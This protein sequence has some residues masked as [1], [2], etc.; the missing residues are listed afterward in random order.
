MTILNLIFLLLRN[1]KYI[2]TFELL[3]SK[4]YL[5]VAI[6]YIH[7]AHDSASPPTHPLYDPSIKLFLRELRINNKIATPF[8]A[9][10][11]T[12][13]EPCTPVTFTIMLMMS[14]IK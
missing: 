14:E 2:C 9:A 6:V 5:A 12:E 7:S 13:T 3:A 1:R 4:L 8:A 11:V 10:V